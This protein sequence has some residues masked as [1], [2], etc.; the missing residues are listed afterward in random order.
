MLGVP[1]NLRS[2]LHVERSFDTYFNTGYTAHYFYCL[3]CLPYYITKH[4][5]T[6]SSFIGLENNK[7]KDN[8]DTYS[9]L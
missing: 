4:Y 1:W 9:Y 8:T 3:L 5:Q 6:I 2:T 7:L